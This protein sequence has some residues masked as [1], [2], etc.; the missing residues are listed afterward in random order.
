MDAQLYFTAN[1]KPDW[2]NDPVESE[3]YALDVAGGQVT[4]LTDRNGPD[5][6]PIVSPDGSK[7]AY[8]GFDDAG[9]AYENTELYVMNRDG[10][11]NAASPAIGTMASTQSSGAPTVARSMPNMT[12]M[13]NQGRAHRPRRLGSRRRKGPVGR[14][15]R[16][17]L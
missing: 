5:G 10:S 6:N 4:A 2:E 12:I 9:R 11:G 8:L 14:R 7:I 15:A 16:P 17:A 1:R 3:I 13:A